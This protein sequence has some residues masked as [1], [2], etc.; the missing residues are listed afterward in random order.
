MAETPLY[1]LRFKPI[2]KTALWGGR[3]LAQMFPDAPAEGPISEAWLVSDVDNN[4]SVVADG[5]LAGTTLRELMQSR[6]AELGLPHHDTFP[7]LIKIIDTAQPLSVQVHPNDE[8]AQRLAGQ[9][10]GKTEAWYVLHAEPGAKIYAGFKA[11]V[12]RAKFLKALHA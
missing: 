3:R 8:Q 10:R 6:R 7:L 12:D 11:G 5:P 2:F 1:P 9:P 4:V